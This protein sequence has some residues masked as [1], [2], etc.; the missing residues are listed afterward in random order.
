VRRAPAVEAVPPEGIRPAQAGLLVEKAVTPLAI[1]ATVVDLAVRGYLRVGQAPGWGS[2]KLDWRLVQLKG[3]DEGLLGYERVLLAGL[4]EGPSAVRKAPQHTSDDQGSLGAD[5]A[6][7]EEG[8]ASVL[9]SNLQAQFRGRAGRVRSALYEHA[10]QQGWFSG[11]PDRVRQGWAWLGVAVAVV[12]AGLTA[13][14]ARQTQRGLMLTS[15]VLAGLALVVAGRRLPKRT[16]KGE[17][18]ASRVRSFRAHLDRARVDA[19]RSVQAA[20][21]LSTY[22]PYW[23]V[24]GVPPASLGPVAEVGAPSQAAWYQGQGPFAV[25][26]FCSRF[27]RLVSWRATLRRLKV[28]GSQEYR[29]WDWGGASDG[30]GTSDGGGGGGGGSW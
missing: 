5:P 25:G 15:I 10:V 2:G 13:L 17:E 11:R 27:E 19:A 18:L 14:L 29:P 6:V 7:V 1:A 20:H 26:E 4:F 24:F 23:I 21:L 9:L 8:L 3:Q 16:R 12:G 30:G 22:V 28:S